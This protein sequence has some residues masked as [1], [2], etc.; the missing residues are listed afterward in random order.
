MDQHPIPQDVTGFQFKLIGS[1]TV[2]QFGFVAVGVVSAFVTFYLPIQGVFGFLIKLICIPTLGLSGFIIAFLP[3]EGRPVDVMATNFAK[4][5]LRP[6][7]YVYHKKG[8]ELSFSTLVLKPVQTAPVAAEQQKETKPDVT[9]Q[10][11]HEKEERLQ[12]FLLHSQHEPKNELDTREMAFLERLTGTYAAPKVTAPAAAA[13]VHA[14]AVK[15][16]TP[17]QPQIQTVPHTAP[18]A[19]QPSQPASSPVPAQQKDETPESLGQKE[20]QLTQQLEQAKQEETQSQAPTAHTVAHQKVL[21]LDTQIQTIHQQKLQLEQELTQL[22]NQL[23][24]Q[25]QPLPQPQP[26]QPVP[27]AAPI[28][29]ATP[30]PAPAPVTVTASAP[31]TA[32]SPV[33]APKKSGAPSVSDTANV[34]I[35][36][37]KDPRG[38][39]LSNILIEVKDSE[40]KPVRAF[41]TNVLGQ[42]ASATPLANGTYTIELEDPKNQHTFDPI[43][44]T[45]SGQIMQPIE[46]IS[47]D[48]REQLRRELFN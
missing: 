28:Q 36:I 29:Q 44:V 2:K 45:T 11:S 43:P 40:K 35:G 34:I 23:A 46:I 9:K 27:T 19:S 20:A 18:V 15:A 4:A 6:N 12:Q 25:K 39:I 10:V 24:A 38:N 22:K 5:L 13:P 33:A 1:M 31:S 16:L 17:I 7:Q 42:F 48:A 3:I 47:H 21:D 8:R 30:A 32:P 37:V 26:F 41:K 14:S